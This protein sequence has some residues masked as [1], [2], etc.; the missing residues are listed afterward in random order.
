MGNEQ[1]KARIAKGCVACGCCVKV[2]PRGAMSVY[3]GMYALV[4]AQRCTGCRRCEAACP[5]QVITV[6][7]RGVAAC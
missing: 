4:D 6:C 2:C 7:A 3:K 1:R 5:A